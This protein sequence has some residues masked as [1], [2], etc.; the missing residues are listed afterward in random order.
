MFTFL[1][2][3]ALI[4]AGLLAIPIILHLFKP[5]KVRQTPFS[6]LRWLRITQQ[7]L[8]RRV[9]WHQIL[10]FILRLL[11][12]LFLVLALAKPVLS[13]R[14]RHT[15][16]ERF[17]VLDVSR[18]MNYE[19]R[20]RPTPFEEG[21]KIA[22]N[23]LAQGTVGDR[24]TVLLTGAT[25]TSLGPLVSD[26]EIYSVRLR[27][28]K[29]G[30]SD[31]DLGSALQ[32]I[33]PM[34]A[35]KRPNTAAE[36]YFITDNHQQSWSQ[37][38][39]T[40]FLDG[41]GM[42]AHI[43]VIEVG[44][45]APQNAWI[46]NA[47]LVEFTNPVRRT[48]RVQAGCIGDE[49]Q[50][51]TVRIT[52]LAG[53]GDLSK[54][55]PLQPGQIVET[56][57]EIPPSYDIKGKVAQIS[58]EPKDALS[59]DDHFWLNLDARGLVR[60]LLIEP[61]TT[62]VASLQPSF[63]LRTAL[64]AIS[65]AENGTLQI[66]R[67]SSAAL[68][69]KDISDADAVFLA[70]VSQLSDTLLLALENRVKAG[71][72]L[73]VF[74]GESIQRPFYDTKLF[75][76]ARP[77]DGLSPAP[78]K[79]LIRPEETGA[80]LGRLTRIQWTHPL[81]SPLFDPTYGDLTQV[82]CR[83]YYNLGDIPP[84][85]ASQV[86]AW[87]DDAHPAILE[88][89]IG[90]GRVMMF[91]TTAN[92]EWSDLPRRKSWVPLLDRLVSRLVGGVV[93]RIF[94]IGEVIAIPIPATQA[95]GNVTVTSPSGKTLQPVLRKLNNQTLV[96]LDSV[97]EIGI[98]NIRIAGA[99]PDAAISF[100]VTPGRGD[101]VLTRTDPDTLRSWW[102][103]AEFEIVRPDSKGAALKTGRVLLWPWLVALACVMLLTEMFFVHWLCPRMNPS[104]V[105]SSV[106]AHGILARTP[107]AS[108][109]PPS[110]S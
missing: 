4:G 83:A 81:L 65:Q 94:Q 45:S 96:R 75:N 55:L 74:L 56:E 14:G 40:S 72:G 66:T 44:V 22:E 71:G 29:A 17:I 7:R 8:S 5:R 13:L 49:G 20:D 100:V 79:T 53:L 39:I 98:H 50:E 26:P 32:A 106:A 47:R 23:L 61:E 21:K 41:L 77:A 48:I 57:I 3:F 69:N 54:K 12:L 99:A 102:T 18:S 16:A 108:S 19:I 78:L 80:P 24:T 92:D 37:G 73:A 89:N 82:R 76:A 87:I 1:A 10:L 63:H 104:V 64:E 62:Q 93:H 33:R 101:S 109:G 58:I 51:R 34:L 68:A 9:Q 88:R 97:E 70:N 105:S 28:A 36:L 84:G 52:K 95:E 90:A 42:P 2:P 59:S 46:A 25:T 103:H 6:S 11:F 67:K 43:H 86:L 15:F 107:S 30:L 91:N 35:R 38:G 31:T 60:V 85:S 110:P 27:A